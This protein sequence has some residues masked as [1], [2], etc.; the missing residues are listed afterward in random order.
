MNLFEFLEERRH[1]IER[2][3]AGT[4]AYMILSEGSKFI[5]R[6]MINRYTEVNP[7][8]VRKIDLLEG[9]LFG[10]IQHCSEP[11][12]LEMLEKRLEKTLD[13]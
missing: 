9:M 2:E 11:K 3:S 7:D 8:V 13:A 5:R 4:S 10:F 1:I 12:H 6:S